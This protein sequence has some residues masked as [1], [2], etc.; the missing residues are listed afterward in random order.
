MRSLTSLKARLDVMRR[1]GG[2]LEDIVANTRNRD[3]MA[4]ASCLIETM[5]ILIDLIE[6]IEEKEAEDR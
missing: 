5:D 6:N 4:I 3:E 1:V 2:H